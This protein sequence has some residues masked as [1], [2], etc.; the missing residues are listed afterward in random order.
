[1]GNPLAIKIKRGEFDMRGYEVVRT[2][3]FASASMI[4]VS[5]SPR[6]V[7]FSSACIHSFK[8]TE[9]ISL[10]IDPIGRMV[11]AVPCSKHFKEKMIWARFNSDEIRVRTVSAS[12]FIM[13]IYELFG[14]DTDK[15]YR[16]RGDILGVDEGIY[17]LFDTK[18]PE[19]FSSCYNMTMPWAAGFGENYYRYKQSRFSLSIRK[20]TYTEYSS[21]PNLQPTEQ[22]IAEKTIRELIE[23][24]Q[25]EGRCSNVVTNLLN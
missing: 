19:I 1:M 8:K 18:T 4:S 13:T 16:L 17:A 15:R 10:E 2:Q 23:E 14:W 3:Y 7:R 9:Y 24:M 12:A 5:F 25:T 11:A 20:A 21:D 6:G 22:E